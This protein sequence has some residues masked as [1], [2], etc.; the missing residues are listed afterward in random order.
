MVAAALLAWGPLAPAPEIVPPAHEAPA[1]AAPAPPGEPPPA[2]LAPPAPAAAAGR[3]SLQPAIIAKGPLDVSARPAIVAAPGR[4]QPEQRPLY[5]RWSFW[6]IA[7]G[8]LATTIVVTIAAT[9]PGPNPYT[10]NA[11]P[12]SITFQ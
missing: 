3:P 9:R 7:G 5:K 2:A 8:L 6:V 10:G 11:P 1:P 12:Y 4:A